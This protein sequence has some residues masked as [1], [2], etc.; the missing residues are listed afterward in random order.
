MSP[1]CPMIRKSYPPG[2]K[3]K[4]RPTPLS[5]YGKELREKQK[6]KNWYNLGEKQFRN[7]VKEILRKKGRVENTAE[8]LIRRLESRL[9][10]VVF[11]LG[12]AKSHSQARQMVS[13]GHFLVNGKTVNIPSRQ[14][15]KRDKVSLHSSSQKSKIF[16]ELKASLKKHQTPSW[17][18]LDADK[19]EGEVIGEPTV[20]EASPPA[21]ISAIF[22]FYSR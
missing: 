14:L 15:K 21:E 1:K 20:E 8:T 12:F 16:S 5:E 10:N 9:D 18:K 7:Y 2:Q 3:S 19:M 17:L 11:R 22:E 13:H 6:L 4:R